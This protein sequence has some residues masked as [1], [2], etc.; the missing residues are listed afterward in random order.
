MVSGDEPG[1]WLPAAA[2]PE[3]GR[4]PAGRGL[5]RKQALASCLG[6]A[7]EL[8]SACIWGDEPLLRASYQEVRRSALHPTSLLLASEAQYRDRLRWNLAHGAFDWLPSRF[9]DA[10]LNDWVQAASPDGA[11]GALIPAAYTYIGYFEAGDD[12][13]FAVADSNGC[14]AGPTRDD[15]I[16]TGFLELVER[17]ATALWWYGR[18][19]RL[20][21]DVST[22]EGAD[23]LVACLA[24]RARRCHILDLTTD[25]GIPVCAAISADPSGEAVAI[26]AAAHFDGIRA[27]IAA[28][29]EM[30]QIELSLDMR[31][32]APVV[33]PDAI[34]SW[35]DA[36]S[37]RTMPHLLPA[38]VT[39][40]AILR[41]PMSGPATV[42]NC[43]RICRDAGLRLLTV[44]LTRPA[45]GVPAVRVVVP[46]MRPIRA[47]FAGGRLLDVPVR[48]G[49][50]AK[51]LTNA[52]LN[53]VPLSI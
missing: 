10:E 52:D 20:A 13:A 48:L 16:V 27:A 32:A 17:D 40:H 29:T 9:D 26:G 53:P 14:A 46:G 47:R 8:V 19:A 37:F 44:D 42:E 33:G 12:T 41:D 22:I 15:A 25:L 23:A 50:C 36:V 51:R 24:D 21:L 5:T 11:D 1:A 38:R 39:Q 4:I 45:I 35:L 34:Q 2:R 6:E 49:W 30:L 7:A 3:A 18:H 28:L 43:I 31:Q